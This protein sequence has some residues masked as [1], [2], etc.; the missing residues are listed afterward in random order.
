MHAGQ[1]NAWKICTPSVCSLSP[2]SARVTAH[3]HIAG[4]GNKLEFVR[5]NLQGSPGRR[6]S[7]RRARPQTP[8]RGSHTPYPLLFP[9]PFTTC[10]TPSSLIS[11]PYRWQGTVNTGVASP[12]GA[13]GVEPAW[14][15]PPET[16]G[17]T[18]APAAARTAEPPL[19]ALRVGGTDEATAEASLPAA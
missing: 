16:A 6:R 15:S 5:I 13:G 3:H 14:E 7:Q 10:S 4:R 12:L 11:R 1:I 18:A 9:Q 19:L 17:A 8:L 2:M